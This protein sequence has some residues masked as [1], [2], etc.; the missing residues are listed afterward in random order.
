LNDDDLTYAKIRLDPDSM[1]TVVAHL[2]GLH[3]SLARALCWA[4]A[5]D[6]VR[7]AELP[8]RDYLAMVLRGLPAEA[9]INLVT[10]TL[11]RAAGAVAF[12]ADPAWAPTGWAEL[13]AGARAA[14]AQAPPGSG[15]QL[16]WTRA[17]AGA[18]RTP[19]ELAVLKGWLDGVDVPDGLVVDTELRWTL[20]KALVAHGAA[21]DAEIEAELDRDDTTAGR[22]EA[23]TA[24]ALRPTAAAKEEA[25]Q[26]LVG[27]PEP[28]N[29]QHRATLAGFW[30]PAQLAVTEPYVAKFHEVAGDLWVR[31]SGE[32]AREFLMVG[33]PTYHISQETVA[34]TEAWLADESRPAPARRLMA[35]GRDSVVRALAA[36]A[37]D[38]A[39]ANS[40]PI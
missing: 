40:S 25:W 29:W 13:A 18:A 11:H 32:L 35:E 20:L 16:A 4:A 23:T 30:H 14:L 24:R 17:Y 33:Y 22:R 10:A 34:A 5:W 6:M 26:L 38:A 2:D 21:G 3:S 7:D 19:E 8:A 15:L 1:A 31:R 37:V 12:Y 27:E 9:D 28:S 39:A 36:R